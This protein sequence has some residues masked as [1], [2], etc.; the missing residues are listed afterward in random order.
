M[1]LV[2]VLDPKLSW[3]LLADAMFHGKKLF[4]KNIANLKKIYVWET[5]HFA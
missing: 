5:F 2:E 4:K 3:S 1:K